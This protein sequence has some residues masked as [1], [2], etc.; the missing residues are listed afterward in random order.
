[1]NPSDPKD[2][3]EAEAK[4]R[5]RPPG[6]TSED[7]SDILSPAEDDELAEMAEELEEMKPVCD[8]LRGEGVPIEKRPLLSGLRWFVQFQFQA[9]N[10]PTGKD[11][12]WWKAHKHDFADLG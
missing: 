9:E 5:E 6:E 4:K 10:D 11:M 8:K 3:A 7:E 12:K 1:M 2:N